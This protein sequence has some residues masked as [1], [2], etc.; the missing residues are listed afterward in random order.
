MKLILSL[1]F[2]ALIGFSFAPAR[3]TDSD[4]KFIQG[5]WRLEGSNGGHSWYLEWKFT[6]EGKFTLEGYPPLFQAGSYRLTKTGPGTLALELYD[7][8]GNFGTENSQI[9]IVMDRRK[10]ELKIKG[11]GPFS[12][13][14]VK[15]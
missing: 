6:P 5:T 14:K 1:L 13:A 3:A 10:D 11:Q 15:R 4:E 2:V 12:R 9:E 8:K 7:Q